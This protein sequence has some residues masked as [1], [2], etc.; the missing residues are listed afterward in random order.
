MT[1]AGL[2]GLLGAVLLLGACSGAPAETSDPRSPTAEAPCQGLTPLGEP[3]GF[4]GLLCQEVVDVA[5]AR[6]GWLHWPISS[7][8]FRAGEPCPPGARCAAPSGN[9]ATVLFTFWAGDPVM[10]VVTKDASGTAAVAADPEP[11]PSW[12]PAP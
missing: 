7:T 8:T 11:L 4:H 9:T 6:L 12:M 5:N 1:G 3:I 10:V 2:W